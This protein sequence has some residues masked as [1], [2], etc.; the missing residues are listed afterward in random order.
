[1]YESQLDLTFS[2]RLREVPGGGTIRDYSPEANKLFDGPVPPEILKAMGKTSV[3]PGGNWEAVFGPEVGVYFRAWAIAKY[4][5][6]V[7]A[8]GKAMHPLPMYANASLHNP[9]T[10]R[11]LLPTRAAA[12]PTM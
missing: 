11:R 1:M 7:A 10:P 6:Q 8:A 12:P 9:L 2:D 4:V 3:T 5:G